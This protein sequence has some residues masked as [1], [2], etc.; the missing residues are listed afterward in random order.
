MV[1]DGAMNGPPFRHYVTIQLGPALRPGDVVVMDNLAAHKVAGVRAAIQARGATLLYL[2]AY[3]PDPRGSASSR[4]SFYSASSSGCCARP[5]RAPSGGS[6]TRSAIASNAS[7]PPNAA[8]TSATQATDTQGEK[9]LEQYPTGWNHPVGFVALGPVDIWVR[10]AIG[11][12]FSVPARRKAEPMAFHR[13]AFPTPP[14]RK[15]TAE[16]ARNA[17]VNRP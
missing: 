15:S 14:A 8:P 17:I 13:R 3:S 12:G 11:E 16:R 5:P 2:P 1:F 10:D 6:G 4:S 9:R 7:R